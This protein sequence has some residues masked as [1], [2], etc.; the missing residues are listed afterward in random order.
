MEYRKLGNTG[1]EV[2]VLGFGA[3]SLGGVFHQVDP[4]ACVQTVWAALDG[5][6]NF[7]DVS[8]AYGETLAETNLGIA[9]KGIARDRYYLATKVGSYS[10]ARGDYDYSAA[11][12]ERSL[13]DSLARLG[14]GYVDLIQ[15]HDIEFADHDQIV[16]ETL[17]ML[18]R[19]KQKG[20][21]RSIGVTG[22]P[23]RVFPGI[24]DKVGPNIIDTILSFCHYALND[25]SLE[26]LI[27]YLR[28]KGVG[29][30]NASPTGMG[31]LTPQGAPNWH[32]AS[33]VIIDG[34]RHA[35]EYC[36]KRGIDIVKL[37]IQFSC[38]QPDIAT[39]LVSTARP[40]NI[41]DNIAY[42]EEPADERLL[43]ELLEVLK[44]IH[45]FNFTRGRLEHRDSLV[46]P[47]DES[48]G[49]ANS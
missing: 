10:E 41:R 9:L 25:D 31:L 49:S 36:H 34:C 44:P 19:L 42:A 33:K 26:G 28:G 6:I 1:L 17:P 37:A 35:V 15:C 38:A 2:S 29:I 24:L 11:R 18:L 3:S 23:L 21:A 4:Q 13:H 40:S 27:P 39:T 5:G 32:P 22:L 12:T 46:G 43:A 30:I 8:P 14:V 45:N 20:L 16:N 48:N 47:T 7:F